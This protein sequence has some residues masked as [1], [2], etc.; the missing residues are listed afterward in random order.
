MAVMEITIGMH[1]THR[2]NPKT[3]IMVSKHY[4]KH[5]GLTIIILNVD[6]S[7]AS[8]KLAICFKPISQIKGQRRIC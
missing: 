8:D 5:V 3:S 4:G 6:S 7:S 2:F 1:G